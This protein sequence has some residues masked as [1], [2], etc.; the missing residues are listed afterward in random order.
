MYT[1]VMGKRFKND[2][3]LLDA[4]FENDRGAMEEFIRNFSKLVYYSIHRSFKIKG[5]TPQHEEVEDLFGEVFLSLFD[6]DFAKLKSFEGRNGCTLAS[7][8]R[9]IAGRRSID[10]LRERARDKVGLLTEDHSSIEKQHT[11]DNPE[12]ALLGKEKTE[13]ASR[14]ISKLPPEDLLFLTLY[15]DQEMSPENIAEIMGV[16]V[17]TVYSKKHRLHEKLRRMIDDE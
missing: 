6:S 10:Y 12:D 17:G 15:Y 2:R 3:E 5:V 14:T 11:V 1:L 9:L 7:W 8:I 13:I 16:S 4:C